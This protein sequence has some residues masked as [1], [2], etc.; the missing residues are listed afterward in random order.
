MKTTTA[1]PIFIWSR[2]LSRREAAAGRQL[3]PVSAAQ[4]LLHIPALFRRVARPPI[5]S[6]A[7]R[8]IKFSGGHP[9][10]SCPGSGLGV[11][12]NTSRA[13]RLEVAFRRGPGDRR[14]QEFHR[15]SILSRRLSHPAFSTADRPTT[16]YSTIPASSDGLTHQWRLMP[17]ERSLAKPNVRSYCQS[18]RSAISTCL[19]DTTQF[20]PASCC[21]SWHSLSWLRSRYPRTRSVH[22]LE[23]VYLAN[24]AAYAVLERV[25]VS[26]P[27][28]IDQRTGRF[29]IGAPRAGGIGTSWRSVRRAAYFCSCLFLPGSRQCPTICGC[30][31]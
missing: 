13:F 15:C 20:C 5:Q 27:S 2:L 23:M 28:R 8:G 7:G 26:S 22:R 9:G 31:S 12:D 29:G 18:R 1:S 3:A 21:S 24:V 19:A 14:H 30:N 4:L 25:G 6:R 17:G 10:R 11:P 16:T